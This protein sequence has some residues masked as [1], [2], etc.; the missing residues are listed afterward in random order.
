MMVGHWLRAMLFAVASLASATVSAQD[1]SSCKDTVEHRRLQK[2]MWDACGGESSREV[3][4]A[5]KAYQRHADAEGDLDSHYNAW[6]CGI[7]Y[8]LD[9]MNIRDAYHI[10]QTM[11]HDLLEG[12]GGKDEQFLAPNMLG[13]VY[14]ACGNIRGAI[15]EFEKAVELIKGT[16]YEASGLSTLYLGMAH[17]YMNS[18]LE[19]SMHWIDEDIQELNRH[20]D[21][22]RYYRGMANAYAFKAMLYFKLQD[23]DKFRE[24][25]RLSDEYEAKNQ[26]GSSGS[27]RPY[28]KIY[29]EML[30]G[31]RDQAHA[32]AGK[33]TNRKDRYI[34]WSDLLRY[35]GDFNEAFKVQRKLMHIRDSIT[36]IMI[37]ENIEQMDD[38]M[39]LMKAEQQASRRA[40]IVLTIAIILLLLLIGGMAFHIYNRRK[41]Q[42]ILQTANHE[43]EE[44]NRRVTA[45]DTMKTEFIRNVSHEIRTPLNIINGFTH[46]MADDS[47]A[48]GDEERQNIADTIEQNTRHI[49]S[50]VNKM[51][52][53]ANEST[54]NLLDNL[55]AVDGLEIGRNAILSMPKTDPQ[56]VVVGMDDRTGDGNAMLETNADSLL[57]MLNCLLENAVKFTDEGHI[58]LAVSKDAEMVCFTVEDTGCGIA[59]DQAAHIFDRFVKGD[60]FREG[61]GLGLAY[62][63]ETTRKL[64]G[65]LV[66]DRDYREGAR[67]ILSLPIKLKTTQ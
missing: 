26:S 65:H 41:Y 42:K 2:A 21:Q 33:L 44:A 12:T 8:S 16:K 51:L 64:G 3:Y 61:L 53:L 14:N 39:W 5:A 38:E 17:I 31:H 15:V 40:N 43:L 32:D 1:L 49:T 28:L 13:Q 50:L 56:H 52:A 22:P 54:K 9:H 11:K 27:F 18:K 47:Q 4:E 37:A 58:L 36:G 57:Q 34:V 25:Q 19:A 20:Q 67:F 7:V 60:E 30:D 48:L 10:T 46:V 24:C 6:V 55:K 35:E 29:Q 62:C 59:D 63:R 23:Y 66:L 45:A